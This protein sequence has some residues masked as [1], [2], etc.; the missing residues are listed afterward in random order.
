MEVDTEDHAM[1]EGSRQEAA[2]G[3]LGRRRREHSRA[4]VAPL[5][6]VSPSHA[7]P[8]CDV[9]RALAE[10]AA[11]ELQ[12]RLQAQ[13]LELQRATEEIKKAVAEH[14]NAQETL[15]VTALF[16]DQNPSPVLRV[17]RDG[18]LLFANAASR[19]LLRSWRCKEGR[20]VPGTVR[21][22]VRHAL[23]SGQVCELEVTCAH[24]TYAFSAAPMVSEG[25]A[26]LY[27]YDITGR[28]A[29]EEAARWSAR[30]DE[31][32]SNTAAHLLQSGNPQALIEDLCRQIMDFLDCQTFFNFLVDEQA[33]KLRL[34]ACAG[35][36]EEQA[37]QITW[38]DYGAAVCGCAARDRKRVIVEDVLNTADPRTERIKSYGIQAY[39]CHPLQVRDRLI[40]TLSFGTRSRTRFRPEHI[41]V[42]KEVSDLVA[43]AMQRIETET[44]LRRSQEDLDRAQTVGQIGSWRM[45]VQRNVLSWSDESYRIF[46]V[47]RGTP[48][49]YET[50]LAAVHPDDRS[51]VDTKW[52]RALGGEPYDIEHRIIVGGQVKW[53]REKASLE[54]DE[55][56]EVLGGF[57]IVQDITERKRTEQILQENEQRLRLALEGGRMGLWE[58]DVQNECGFWDERV[59]ELIGADPRTPPSATVFFDYV[60]PADRDRLQVQIQDILATGGDFQVEFRVV[61]PDQRIAWLTSR[62]R[63][64]RDEQNR[65]VR[66]LG[67]LYDVTQRKEME[68]ELRRLNDQLAEEVRAQT[69]ELGNTVSRLEEEVAR[70]RLAEKSLRERSQLLEGF[71]RHTITPLAFM[72]RQFNFVQVNDAYAKVDDREPEDFVGKNHFDLYPNAENQAIFEQVVRTKQPYHALAKPFVYPEHPERGVSYWNWQ[73]TPLLDD[74]GEVRF[75]VLNLQDV[76]ARQE[77]MRELEKRTSQLQRLTA[78]LSEAEDRERRRLAELLHDDLQQLL[79]GSKLRL[80]ILARRLKGTPELREI[81]DETTSLIAESIHKSRGLSHELSPPVLHHGDL[82]EV[83]QWLIE[84][85][86]ATCGL[87]VR[88]KIGAGVDLPSQTLKTFLYKAAREMLFNVVK[89]AN[90]KQA[91]IV[92]QQRNRVLF[93]TVS[94][95]GRGFEAERLDVAGQNGF[96]L[97]NIRERVQFLGGSLTVQSV[98]DRG[99]RFILTIPLNVPGEAAAQKTGAPILSIPFR[100]AVQPARDTPAAKQR[101]RILLVDDHK[102][103][104][105][106]L[107]ALLEEEPD[108]EV[109]GQAGNGRDAITLTAQLKPDVVVMD[110]VMPIIDGEE[111]TRQIRAQ[112]P[113][114]RV[115]ALSMLEEDT[116][117]ER[118]LKAGAEVFLSKAGPSEVIAAA[119][120]RSS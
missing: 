77:T 63:V 75:L 14:Q 15:R 48:L 119:I 67:V 95:K 81:V 41:A 11:E 42:M 103:M 9:D 58:W 91:A 120:R 84:Q 62:G 12:Q 53:V 114:V 37:R 80:N 13:T 118:M 35:I 46:G 101:F 61:R 79:V 21:E 65:G 26:N 97:F 6:P 47:P 7:L 60:H 70:R 22:K 44:A 99:S 89:H 38:L 55:E 30:R 110:V 59:Y 113:H 68:A 34:N 28:K 71:F 49:T 52:Q 108:I 69:E 104:R 98:P 29:A 109:V 31:L 74:A 33:G 105:D 24:T 93:V 4:A 117:R 27:G 102:V 43:V 57:G 73:L 85:I 76:T 16:P 107:A 56:D 17:S 39:C 96:G 90:V 86:H 36:P 45:D 116:T 5:R 82:R 32:L 78:E 111:A 54:F 40:G 50:F 112:W 83:L 88:L 92:V 100:P 10:T 19:L 66:M 64:L 115:V 94:D 2:A 20:A 25:C 3:R 18:I 87:R 106:G 51:H 72:D 8:P 1:T 23:E